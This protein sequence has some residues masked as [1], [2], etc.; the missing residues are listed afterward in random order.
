MRDAPVLPAGAAVLAADAAGRPLLFQLG[1]NSL[2]F[3]GHPG[4]KSA[5]IEDLIMEFDETPEGTAETLDRLREAQAG[6]AGAL[7]EI[8]VGLVERHRLDVSRPRPSNCPARI[9]GLLSP[10]Q[11]WHPFN[12]SN[13]KMRRLISLNEPLAGRARVVAGQGKRGHCEK[14]GEEAHHHHGQHRSA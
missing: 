8:M 2:G 7:A 14:N 5:M 13:M 12:K 4:I 6:I 11:L 9:S 1:D 10:V 3:L